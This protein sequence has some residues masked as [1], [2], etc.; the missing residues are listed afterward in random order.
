[1]KIEMKNGLPFVSV[2]LVHG[3]E[4][5]FLDDILLDTGSYG[6]LFPTDVVV[7]LGIKFAQDDVLEEI[8][9]VGGIEFIV[10]KKIDCLKLGNFVAN[11]F[12]IDV[13]AMN[14]SFAI[15]GIVGMTFL[16]RLKVCID[17]GR[18]EIYPSSPI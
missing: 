15:N 10:R 18:V 5:V 11:H 17:L 7:D 6:C 3:Q 14:Y 13:G 12:E 4:E 1:M 8:E 9:G 2:T 16:E